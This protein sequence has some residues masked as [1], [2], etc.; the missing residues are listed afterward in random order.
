MVEALGRAGPAAL[1]GEDWKVRSLKLEELLSRMDI[2]N[3]GVD[4]GNSY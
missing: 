4:E 1:R 2:V 3:P